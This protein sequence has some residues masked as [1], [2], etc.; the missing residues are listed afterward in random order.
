M[1]KPKSTS[2]KIF[3]PIKN[4]P[5]S[6]NRL[7]IIDFG[8]L[9]YH[10][11]F[12]LISEKNKAYNNI[13]S[14][15]LERIHWKANM[16]LEIL[17]TIQL[18]NPIDI[19]I[20]LEG[21]NTWRHDVFIKYYKEN[22]KITYDKTGYY[23]HHDNDITLIFKENDEFKFAKMKD[24][25]NIPDKEILYDKLPEHIRKIVDV[26]LPKY[27]GD[28]KKKPWDFKMT[29]G[30][31]SDLRDSFAKD[32]AKIFRAK[33]VVVDNAEGDD[34]IYTTTVKLKDKYESMILISRDSDMNQLLNI[35]NF[36]IYNHL[37]K[38]M[39]ECQNPEDYLN[40]KILSGDSSD[41]I[42]GIHIP[43]NRTKLGEAGA[44]TLYEGLSGESCYDRAKNDGWEKQYIRNRQL[45][46]LSFCPTEIQEN[47]LNLIE[48]ANPE[49]CPFWELDVMELPEKLKTQIANMKM[50]GYYTLNTKEEIE[51]NSGNFNP[52]NLSQHKAKEE[53]SKVITR[54]GSTEDYSGVFN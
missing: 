17:D 19:I 43:G 24:K 49:F 31:F 11:L 37:T 51:K 20:A 23:I 42:P 18:F 27:K 44:K 5:I 4:Y 40:I 36:A 29:K 16:L 9:A 32:L 30:E 46:D 47:I 6:K 39:Q 54:Y 26:A 33:T 10:K 50:W 21:R 2:K 3:A 12:A 34:I 28:R 38:E 1:A 45:I 25:T 14:A 41:S 7:M 13:D 8:S 15:Y 48:T 35:K 52:Q 22:H 53:Q